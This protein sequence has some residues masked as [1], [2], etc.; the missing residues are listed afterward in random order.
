[1]RVCRNPDVKCAIVE[2][3]NRTLKSKLFKWFTRTN[4][5]RYV[6]V[7]DNFI[8]GYNDTMHLSTGMAPSLV[9]DKHVLH[10]WERIRKR[11]GKIREVK[12]TPIYSVGQTVRISKE[13]LRF[14]RVLSRTGRSRL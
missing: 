3:F 11:Q 7:L 12:A 5:Y 10:I 6:D 4:S 1:M 13:K 8:T 9:S 14:A 2:R